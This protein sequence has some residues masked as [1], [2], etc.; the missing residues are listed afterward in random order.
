MLIT[1]ALIVVGLF[2]CDALEAE[3]LDFVARLEPNPDYTQLLAE[4]LREG[5]SRK[6][7]ENRNRPGEQ[8]RAS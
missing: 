7:V 8:L 1:T 5:W 6:D 4:L 3:F 2:L